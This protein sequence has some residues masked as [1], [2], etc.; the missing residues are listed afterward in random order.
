MLLVE[1]SCIKGHF[2]DTSDRT[3]L[4]G[5]A[6]HDTNSQRDIKTHCVFCIFY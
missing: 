4:A 6:F 1:V 3:L 2:I 5:F